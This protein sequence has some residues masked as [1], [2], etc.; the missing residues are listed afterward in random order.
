MRNLSISWLIVW[1]QVINKLMLFVW[2][3]IGSLIKP[4]RPKKAST[5]HMLSFFVSYYHFSFHL[6]FFS[7]AKP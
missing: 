3:P 1:P 6:C 2:G 5:P 7:Q 4:L